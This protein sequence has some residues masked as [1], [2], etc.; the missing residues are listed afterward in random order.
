M[1]NQTAERVA[2]TFFSEWIAR[3]GVPEKVTTDH[4]VSSLRVTSSAVWHGSLGCTRLE[5]RLTIRRLT[6]LSNASIGN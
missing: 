1:S 6:V 4:L 5:R 3:Y 2:Q